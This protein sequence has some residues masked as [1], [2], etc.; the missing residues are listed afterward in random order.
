VIVPALA[1]VGDLRYKLP[2][3]PASARQRA[4]ATLAGVGLTTGD[5]VVVH[6]GAGSPLKE[7]PAS[8]W[9]ELVVRLA[10][11][12]RLVFTGNGELQQHR[13]AEVTRDVR[14]CVDLI[15]RLAWPEFVHVLAQARLVLSVDTVAAHV[16]SAVGT[17]CVALWAATTR[18]SHWR[19][20]GD[21]TVLTNHVSCA[22]CFR[23]RGCEA[24]AC[25]RGV[26]ADAVLE[27]VQSRLSSARQLQ[28]AACS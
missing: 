5:Y 8:S 21:A 28:G 18:I 2:P 25:I 20:L 15:G 7:W 10:D 4:E 16:A 6:M 12:H 17:P 24:M 27:A 13:A 23:S 22:P 14:Q 3:V 26:T 11:E 1:N 19:P 9:R